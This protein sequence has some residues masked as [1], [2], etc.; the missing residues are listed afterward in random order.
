[1]KRLLDWI[2]SIRRDMRL[3][4]LYEADRDHDNAVSYYNQHVKPDPLMSSLDT[5]ISPSGETARTR[6]AHIPDQYYIPCFKLKGQ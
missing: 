2:V 3:T 1:M 6:E 4:A 5:S